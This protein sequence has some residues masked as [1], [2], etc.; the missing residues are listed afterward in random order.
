MST[1]AQIKEAIKEIMRDEMEWAKEFGLTGKNGT[2]KGYEG[3]WCIFNIGGDTPVK[4]EI[5]W[6]KSKLFKPYRI[7]PESVR[8]RFADG[9]IVMLHANGKNW[10]PARGQ[11][12]TAAKRN[13]TKRDKKKAIGLKRVEC[14][15]LPEDEKVK[16]V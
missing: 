7:V 16:A 4:A 5:E 13:E 12:K 11:D 10:V 15:V 14:W 2:A 8:V 1:S 3:G 9:E 6:V